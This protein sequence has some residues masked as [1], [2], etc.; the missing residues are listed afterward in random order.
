MHKKF[1]E[2]LMTHKKLRALKKSDIAE[3]LKKLKPPRLSGTDLAQVS[4]FKYE[5]YKT[6][7]RRRRVRTNGHTVK[8]SGRRRKEDKEAEEAA[9][10]DDVDVGNGTP[11]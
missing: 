7:L 1:E 5:T 4:G 9:G 10:G 11:A 2:L 6:T 3:L 8:R